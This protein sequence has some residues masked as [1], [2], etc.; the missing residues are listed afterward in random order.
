VRASYPYTP[1]QI[2]TDLMSWLGESLRR[3]ALRVNLSRTVVHALSKDDV[4]LTAARQTKEVHRRQALGQML[5][6]F[7]CTFL[8]YRAI[9]EGKLQISEDCLCLDKTR[10]IRSLDHNL[11]TEFALC[12]VLNRKSAQKAVEAVR[13][14]VTAAGLIS[15]D[16]RNIN[17][18]EVI[19]QG[20]YE[21]G[22][23]MSQVNGQLKARKISISIAVDSV[24]AVAAAL[25]VRR[26]YQRYLLDVDVRLHGENGA[27]QVRLAKLGKAP[28]DFAVYGI[29]SFSLNLDSPRVNC[30]RLVTPLHE[31]QTQVLTR[32]PHQLSH[33][34]LPAGGFAQMF[35]RAKKATD[36]GRK[37]QVEEG[38][39]SALSLAAELSS[40]DGVLA[41]EPVASTLCRTA[42]LRPALLDDLSYNVHVGLF[43][44]EKFLG[45]HGDN[46]DRQ[47][48]ARRFAYAFCS[49]YL[50]YQ[51]D[52]EAALKILIKNDQFRR[53]Y[54]LMAGIPPL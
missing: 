5:M 35:M 50:A 20:V 24:G 19:A 18:D 14:Q 52:H 7:G 3:F 9:R 23:P 32:N 34:I 51:F 8:D 33:V 44:N 43:L 22:Q 41:F 31:I 30:F 26:N 1:K 46:A 13:L 53:S 54:A 40:K 11:R 4:P 28:A 39:F 29:P 6:A 16:M 38:R 49:E 27:E 42:R 21:A 10:L 47:A 45:T 12:R 2:V 17:P 37:C 25:A 36:W 15:G 48:T